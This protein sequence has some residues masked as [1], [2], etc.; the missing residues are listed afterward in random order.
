[1]NMEMNVLNINM[2]NNKI[3]NCAYKYLNGIDNAISES[4]LVIKKRKF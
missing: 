1:M 4:I 2:N 3:N